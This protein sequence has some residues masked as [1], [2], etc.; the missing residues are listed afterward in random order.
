ALALDPE[1]ASAWAL[2]GINLLQDLGQPD[3]AWAALDEAARRPHRLTS[4]ERLR[5]EAFMAGQRWH[6]RAAMQAS[7]QL[8]RERPNDT[9]AWNGRGTTLFRLRGPEA[10]LETLD[11]IRTFE[12]FETHIR[13]Y[14]RMV[15][16]IAVGR[17]VEARQV[18]PA[19]RNQRERLTLSL[20]AAA[21]DAA[22]GEVDSLA[23]ELR[24]EDPRAATFWRAVLLYVRG[25]VREADS[26]LAGLDAR[27]WLLHSL[28]AGRPI[29]RPARPDTTWEGAVTAALA[30]DTAAARAEL[31]RLTADTLDYRVESGFWR[32]AL[33]AAIAW[34]AGDW[35]SV[36][37]RTGPILRERPSVGDI[38]SAV[39]WIVGDAYERL[40]RLDSATVLLNELVQPGRRLGFPNTQSYGAA[41]SYLRQHLIV[42]LA[43]QGRA[44]EARRHWEIFRAT[45]T[46][47]D[48]ELVPLVEEARRAL[49]IAERRH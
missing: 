23:R 7:D 28:A 3:S 11:H 24:Q 13:A 10:V 21:L 15:G 36:V 19:L 12:P 25:E 2:F 45:F 48:P 41:H 42:L 16:L 32:A 17:R 33:E 39:L 40:G 6:L 20:A 1:F 9:R 46:N 29:Q 18:A 34:R 43:R 5:L 8:V 27:P 37:Q 26:V 47:P 4:A 14:N 38:G 31:P 49:E 30:G 22:W 44:D 35:Q